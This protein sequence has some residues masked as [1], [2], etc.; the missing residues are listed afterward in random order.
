MQP[1]N[2][3]FLCTGNSCRSQMAEALLRARGGEVF[4]AFSAGTDPQGVNPLTVKALAEI[5]I[6]TA[7]LRSKHVDEVL[8]ETSIDTLIVVC[9]HAND[10]CPA[11][12]VAAGQR[13]FWPFPDPAGFQGS[14]EERLAGFRQVRE[15]ID[16]RIKG[17]LA[18]MRQTTA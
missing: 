12:L 16:A 4:H 7:P 1:T 3:L 14:D 6:D 17:W 9:D 10:N 13:L 8:A 11:G 15:Q 5:G 18:E 2:V